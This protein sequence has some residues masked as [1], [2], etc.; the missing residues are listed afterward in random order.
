MAEKLP[1]TV[2]QFIR[3]I[4]RPYRWHLAGLVFVGLLWAIDLSLRPYLLKIILDKVNIIPSDQVIHQ[5]IWVILLYLG[6]SLAGSLNLR[7][8]DFIS[9]KMIPNLRADIQKKLTYYVLGHSHSYFQNNMAGSLAG[10]ITDVSNGVKE[11]VFISIDRFLCNSFALIVAAFTFA[12]VSP[13]LMLILL[14]WAFFFVGF[15]LL[16]SYKIH[17]LSFASSESRTMGVGRVVDLLINSN[18]IRL[19]TKR[20]FEYSLLSSQLE[21]S[22]KNEQKLR[23]FILYVNFVQG[24]SFVTMLSACIGFLIWGRQQ[25]IVSVGD[26][27]LILSVAITIVELMWGLSKDFVEF[28]EELGR[29]SQG[30]TICN[31]PYEIFDH[32]EAKELVV[33]QGRIAFSGVHFWYKGATPLFSNLSVTIEPGQKVGLVGFSGSGKSTFASLLMRLFDIN[34]GQI[35]IDGQD[36]AGVSLSSLYANIALIPQEPTLLNRSVIDNV[37]YGN[38]D[39]TEEEIREACRQAHADDFIQQL[40]EGY[41]APVGER[42]ARLSGGQRQ[43]I[44]IARAVLKNAPVLILDEATSALDTITESVIQESLD[45]LMV[46][47][48]ALVIAHRLPTLR[49]MDRILVFSQ[50]EIVEDG[51]HQ[52]L[53]RKKGLYTRLWRSQVDGFIQEERGA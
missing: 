41:N 25:N 1:S 7:F 42:G 14:A 6:I 4:T 8:Y 38:I 28:S 52:Q 2:F 34:A 46:G 19:F 51:T 16:C 43:R 53:I 20:D 12:I 44:A 31:I 5:T 26:F 23:W 47:R 29:V 32:K 21:V 35:C 40:P 49:N 48:T 30:L 27:A 3:V 10:K 11:I 33:T 13:V 45:Q 24:L 22:V 17:R 37:R 15:T 39:A 18:I 36:I 9:L 50:G